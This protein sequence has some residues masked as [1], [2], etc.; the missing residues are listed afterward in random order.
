MAF[1]FSRKYDFLPKL[2]VANKQLEV[3]YETKLLGVILTSD[4]KWHENTK[5]I[6]KKANNRIW[7]LRRLKALGASTEKLLEQDRLSIRSVLEFGAPIWTGGL[8]KANI[9]SIE[10]V[11]KTCFKVI[12]STGY[13]EA[14]QILKETRTGICSEAAK[15]VLFIY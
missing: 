9:S 10:K 15:E 6:V 4:C 13:C 8:T 3:I 11:K 14:L 12:L 5:Y 1:N 7:Y 2:N